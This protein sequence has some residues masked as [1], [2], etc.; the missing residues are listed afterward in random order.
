[1]NQN[2]NIA[3]EDVEEIWDLRLDGCSIR[4]IHEFKTTHLSRKAISGVL[5]GPVPER[6]KSDERLLPQ[7]HAWIAATGLQD[8]AGNEIAF[9]I[10]RFDRSLTQSAYRKAV[11]KIR[12]EFSAMSPRGGINALVTEGIETD[13]ARKFVGRGTP[14]WEIGLDGS[15]RRLTGD[16]F[17]AEASPSPAP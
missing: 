10:V 15:T 16:D 2:R 14:G 9:V 13:V 7:R 12:K 17:E 4:Y 3:P 8:R 5:N 6:F 1:M 11:A